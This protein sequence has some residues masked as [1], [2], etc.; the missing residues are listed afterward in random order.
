MG[1]TVASLFRPAPVIYHMLGPMDAR[2][3]EKRQIVRQKRKAPVGELL[4]WAGWS[5]ARGGWLERGAVGWLRR[6]AQQPVAAAAFWGP[7][8]VLP[9]MIVARSW[10]RR[11][12]GAAR[13]A[14][15]DRGRGEAGVSGGGLRGPAVRWTEGGKAVSASVRP[16]ALHSLCISLSFFLSLSLQSYCVLT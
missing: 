10:R 4:G 14:G 13:G 12:G 5:T 2:P 3:R 16:S 6:R 11:R 9:S 8:F 15:R 7:A 1:R